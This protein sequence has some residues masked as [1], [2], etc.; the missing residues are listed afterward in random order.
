MKSKKRANA[1]AKA[2]AQ[3]QQNGESGKTKKQK[4]TNIAATKTDKYANSNKHHNNLITS[5]DDVERAVHDIKH[6]DPVLQ[7]ILQSSSHNLNIPDISFDATTTSS[8]S[9][10]SSSLLEKLL[11]PLPPSTFLTTCFRNKAVYIQANNNTR[12]QSL[13][14]NYMF[15]LNVKQIFEETSS[16]SIFLW[17]PTTNETNNIKIQSPPSASTSQQTLQS[18]ELQDPEMAYLLHTSSHYATYCRAP[19]ELEQPLVYNMLKDT[20]I[21]C[22]QYE[23]MNHSNDDNDE[24]NNNVY[25]FKTKMHMK[26]M[27]RGEVETFIGTKHHLT[28][29]HIDFQEN[30]TIQLSGCKKWTLKQSTI[31]H[32]LRGIT[33]HYKNTNDVV[34]NQLLASKLSIPNFNYNYGEGESNSFGDEVEIILNAGDV[35]YF[36]A[37]MWHKVETMEYGVSINISLMGSNYAS[38]VCEALEHLLLKKDEWRE[39]ICNKKTNKADDVGGASDD[40]VD[41]VIAKLDSLLKGLPDIVREFQQNGGAQCI[42]PP[43]LRQAPNYVIVNDEAHEDDD[44]YDVDEESNEQRNNLKSEGV[45]DF[46]ETVDEEEIDN[47]EENEYDV[48]ANTTDNIIDITSFQCP[49]KYDKPSSKHRLLKNPLANMMRMTDITSS[50]S[51]GKSDDFYNQNK[52]NCYVLNVCY[53]GDEQH[54]PSVRLVLFDDTDLLEKICDIEQNTDGQNHALVYEELLS[55]SPLLGALFYYGYVNWTA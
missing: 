3:P 14:S 9:S 48:E 46:E 53:A 30:F 8:S 52:N 47:C 17:I 44:E 32:P 23:H 10:S 31:K 26:S 29:W 25:N 11:Y 42:L 18:I 12:I 21:G 33:P 55:D 41:P 4:V 34:E 40:A 49:I 5:I 20:G 24:D 15:D 54:E 50:C 6:S 16:D 28:N 39:I 19:P 45:Q 37:G 38:V 22:G 7:L 2:K 43:V 27:G 13:I 51:K 1:N 36:P 35:L